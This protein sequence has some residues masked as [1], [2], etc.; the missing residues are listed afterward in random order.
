MDEVNE[1][2][3]TPQQKRMFFALCKQLGWNAE[4]TK[5]KVK[6][7]F[8]LDSFA[9]ISKEQLSKIIDR[10]ALKASQRMVAALRAFFKMH[11][12]IRESEIEMANW[13]KSK[14][15]TKYTKEYFPQYL[16][17]EILK[18][19]TIQEKRDV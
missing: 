12:E 19:F 4:S 3:A 7:K 1:L 16:T 11:F 5:E 18:Y 15:D 14:V 2:Q 17:E 13:D 8:K 6:N 9:N 10:M